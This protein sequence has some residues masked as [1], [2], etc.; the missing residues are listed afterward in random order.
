[1]GHQKPQVL[2][3]YLLLMG[4]QTLEVVVVV[5]II[6]RELMVVQVVLAS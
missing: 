4:L 6:L 5:E 1:M 2:Q 3:Q